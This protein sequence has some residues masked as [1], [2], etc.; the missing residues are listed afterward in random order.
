MPLVRAFA[1]HLL[2]FAFSRVDLPAVEDLPW[3]VADSRP[4]VFRLGSVVFAF[5]VAFLPNLLRATSVPRCLRGDF[6]LLLV[7]PPR[8][9]LL[10]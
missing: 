2:K 1:L 8:S 10:P 4:E 6:L 3:R 9:K 7:A 5:A